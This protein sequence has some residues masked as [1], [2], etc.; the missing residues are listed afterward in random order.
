ML[1]EQAS[2]FNRLNKLVDLTVMFAAFVLAYDVRSGWGG[3]DD[4]DNYL[5]I[6]LIVIPVWFFLFNWIGLY[7]SQR[8]DKVS[9]I[10]AS[11]TKMHL[12]GGVV[13][14]S[15]I[16][17]V[18]PHGYSRGLFSSFLIFSFVFLA[19]ERILLK[20]VLGGIRRRGLNSRNILIVGTDQ[21]ARDFIE[22]AEQHADWGLRIVGFLQE[23]DKADVRRIG[24]Y[25]ML[26]RIDRL[27]EVCKTY[28]VD[29]V[30]FCLPRKSV[31]E[32]DDFV[33]D[34]ENMGITVRMVLDVYESRRSRRELSFFHEQLPMLTFYSKPFDAGKLFLK[35]C[36]DIA[37]SAAGLLFTAAVLPFIALAV[38]IDSKGPL[39]FGQKR[40]GENGRTFTCWKIRSMRV[41]AEERKRELMARNEMDGAMFKIKHDPR[42]TRIGKFLR[43]TSLDELPQFWNVLKGEMSLVGTRP[44]TPDEVALYEN[45]QRKRI[46]IKPGITGFWQVSGRNQI[47]KFDEVVRLDLEYIEKWS[48][49]LDIKILLKTVRV[50]FVREGSC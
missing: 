22:L 46:C 36:L 20:A 41:D 49:W 13:A 14:S 28:S 48:L 16:Y 18:E 25:C 27:E 38:K 47:R 3:L 4:F 43:K 2:L 5:W 30:V 19:A 11:L 44:P 40:V 29:E 17:F 26:G 10:L 7:T 15:A 1:K 39:F 8:I 35:R 31:T 21:K 12:I 50:V 32:V 33:R 23:Q 37:G 9:H 24:G 45:W 42:I 34:M 6:M